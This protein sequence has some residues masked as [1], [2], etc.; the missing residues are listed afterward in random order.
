MTVIE[1]KNVTKSYGSHKV[2]NHVNF[3]IE[4]GSLTGI[5]GRNGVGK[6][7]LMKIVAGYI[8]KTAGDV[9]VFSKNPFNS[10]KVSAN[11]ILIDDLMSFSDKLS[12]A[13][14]FKETARF[15]TNWD[16]DLAD[17]LFKYFGFNPNTRHHQ[18][19]KGKKSTFNAIIGIASH[20]PLTIFDEPTT[21]MD[22]AARQDFYRALLKDY[23]AYPRTILLSSHHLEEIEDLLENILLVHDSHVCYHGAITD[24]QEMF[25]K[26]IGKE[27]LMMQQIGER[28]SFGHRNNGPIY[29]TYIENTLTPEDKLAMTAN[30]IK[31]IPVS[32]ND[33]YVILTASLKGGID[34]VFD[35]T[36]TL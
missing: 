20:C 26:L 36:K 30:G 7:T 19:S 29:E 33:A 24:L 31:I 18:L 34:D 21:G 3:T 5:I 25:V 28:K 32:A 27:K 13:E 2:L 12:L 10:L 17:R 4:K 16:Q 8:Q 6:T 35:R 23:I 15:Y 9:Y 1:F 22:T 11:S 14:I